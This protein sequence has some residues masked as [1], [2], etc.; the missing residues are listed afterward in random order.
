MV[1]P[2]GAPVQSAVLGRASIIASVGDQFVQVEA[3]DVGDIGSAA[4]V[5]A[6]LTSRYTPSRGPV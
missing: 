6:S 4:N 3:A 5:D 1:L 2:S